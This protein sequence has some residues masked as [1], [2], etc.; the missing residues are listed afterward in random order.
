MAEPE[1][2]V[3][4]EGVPLMIPQNCESV[5]VA[6][7]FVRLGSLIPEGILIVAVLAR[8]PEAVP[9]ILHTAVKVAVPPDGKST[10]ALIFPEPDAGP[11]APPAYTA[12]HETELMAEGKLSLTIVPFEKLGPV[13]EA[14]IV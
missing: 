2:I 6:E 9:E 8:L 1:Q 13:L 10:E 7:L 12:V 11:V 5:S 14:V 3:C 4:D